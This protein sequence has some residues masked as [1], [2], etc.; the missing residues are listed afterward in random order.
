M[1]H[2]PTWR[3][4][5][6]SLAPP[7]GTQRASLHSACNK[8]RTHTSTQSATRS[9]RSRQETTTKQ[10]MHMPHSPYAACLIKCTASHLATDRL[11]HAAQQPMSQGVLVLPYLVSVDTI[12]HGPLHIIQHALRG[13]AQH[14]A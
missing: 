8:Q 12:I 4:I 6:S 14:N 9:Y 5:S 13:T 10:S 11:A 2:S 7:A 3:A 1:K